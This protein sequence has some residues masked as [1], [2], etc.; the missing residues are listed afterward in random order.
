MEMV[1]VLMGMGIFGMVI[2]T[3]LGILIGRSIWH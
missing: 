1:W 3:A 2:G